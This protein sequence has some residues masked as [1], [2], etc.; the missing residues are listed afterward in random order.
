MLLMQADLFINMF[1]NNKN[2]YA[3]LEGRKPGQTEDAWG[4]W[5][6]DSVGSYPAIN[7]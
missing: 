7:Q 1:L 2:K 5:S 6:P 3:Q 4:V